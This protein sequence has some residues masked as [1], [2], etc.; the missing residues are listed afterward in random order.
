MIHVAVSTYC[1]NHLRLGDALR[2][3]AAMG[4]AAV[5]IP[6]FCHG[7]DDELL[8]RDPA[9]L[10]EALGA[11]GLRLAA[12]YPRPLSVRTEGALRETVDGVKRSIDLA[13]A[14]GCE[15]IVFS[16][17]LPREEFPYD[18]LASAALDCAAHASGTSVRICLENHA[19]WPL[20][21]AEDYRRCGSIWGHPN[22]GIT[23][24]TGHFT[25]VGQ[26]ILA[27]YEE[28]RPHVAHLHLK[29]HRGPECVPL[30]TGETD[31]PAFFRRLREDQFEGFATVEIEVKDRRHVLQFLRE[32]RPYAECLAGAPA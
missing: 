13:L 18:R 10:R 14:V 31:N 12:L 2:E 28:L 17:L 9:R 32:A 16:P 3:F 30:G 4:Y 27:F 7:P 11:H 22:L 15:R 19:G 8:C 25:A 29:D 5:E 20:S 24:D 1:L 21:V 6:T 26:D 23:M